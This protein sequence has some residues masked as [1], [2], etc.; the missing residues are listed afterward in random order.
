MKYLKRSAFFLAAALLTASFSACGEEQPADGAVGTAA[1][2]TAATSAAATEP[3]NE[4]ERRAMV[5]DGLPEKD[6]KGA[7]FVITTNDYMDYEYWAE[8]TT[9]DL[10]EDVVF[11]RNL[12]FS[13]RF[14][15][16][17]KTFTGVYTVVRDAVQNSVLAGDDSYQLVAQHAVT[18][19]ALAKN[20]VFYNW[21]SV[22]GVDFDKPWWSESAAENLSY[23][24]KVLFLAVGDL[25]LNTQSNTYCMFFDKVKAES[26]KIGNIY[27]IVREGGWTLDRVSAL[28]KGIY[29]DTNGDGARDAGD[30]YGFACDSNTNLSAFLW[31]CGNPI[32]VSGSD[33]V[34]SLAI[35]TEKMPK[36]LEKVN[37]L[38]FENTGS[39]GTVTT[40]MRAQ[41]DMFC[42]GNVLMVTGYLEMALQNFRYNENA[43]GIVPS[44]KL[45]EAQESYKALVDGRHAL[46]ALPKSVKNVELSGIVTEALCAESYKT[47]IPTFV[48]TAMKV[49]LAN[50]EDTVEM[51]DFIMG[52]RT[53]DFGYIYDNGFGNT[54]MLL[55]KNAS[56]NTGGF[57]SFY[58]SKEEAAKTAYQ[59]LFDILEKSV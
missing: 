24:H 30:Y 32:M 45:D 14:N 27:D 55:L 10:I 35:N 9:G 15:V 23:K 17:L 41:R 7:D 13:E 20:D 2:T 59:A 48:E 4:F 34:P 25:A 12:K 56:G 37:G 47:V 36:I 53:F 50:D 40:A 38:V 43:Y 42:A 49:K 39:A 18:A 58:A 28:V 33:G 57:A 26:Y 54:V 21:Y 44:P 3:A 5:D 19:G 51:V 46:L 22:P 52:G 11:N 29:S 6:F 1:Q 31:S 8:T 16:S